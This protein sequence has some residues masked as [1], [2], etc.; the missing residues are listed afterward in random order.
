MG[1]ECVPFLLGTCVIELEDRWR[2]VSQASQTH[3][4]GN[5]SEPSNWFDV[6]RDVVLGTRRYG[7]GR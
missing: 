3:R 2:P 7:V 4:R 1:I 6:R 5:G